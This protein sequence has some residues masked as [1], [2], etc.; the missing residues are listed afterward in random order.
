MVE[1]T[2][3]A[4]LR[5]GGVATVAALTGCVSLP[6]DGS[7]AE[8]DAIRLEMFDM[9][10]SSGDTVCVRP[11]GEVVLLDLWATWCAPCKHQMAELRTV[12]EEFPDVHML[13]IT[14]EDDDRAVREFWRAYEGTWPVASDPALET[15]DAFGVNRI[16]T[17]LIF[18]ARGAEVWRHVGLAAAETIADRLRRPAREYERGDARTPSMTVDLEVLRVGFAFTA[19]AATFFAPCAFPLLPGHVTFYLGHG[20]DGGPLGTRLRRAGVVGVV[21]SVGAGSPAAAA[22]PFAEH[23]PHRPSRR[24]PPCAGRPRA[25]LPVPV[26]VRRTAAPGTGLTSGLGNSYGNWQ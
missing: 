25:D 2:R 4:A 12:R 15:N 5:A 3:R 13:S 21:A 8:D 1:Y 10:G 16:P 18:D 23:R 9:G 7:I 14:N 26:R 6:G 11:L 20:D 19:G 24:R 22:Y 17:L